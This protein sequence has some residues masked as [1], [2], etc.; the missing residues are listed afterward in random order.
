MNYAV[1]LIKTDSSIQNHYFKDSLSFSRTGRIENYDS[2]AR[3]LNT[4]WK[5]SDIIIVKRDELNM[6]IL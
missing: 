4:K 5:S 3:L 1:G 6:S 2:S